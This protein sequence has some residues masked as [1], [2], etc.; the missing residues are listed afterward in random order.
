MWSLDRLPV[1]EAGKLALTNFMKGQGVTAE[2]G[3]VMTLVDEDGN[4]VLLVQQGSESSDAM[5][6]VVDSSNGQDTTDLHIGE[7]I[8][9]YHLLSACSYSP[10]VRMQSFWTENS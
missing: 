4:Q 7:P 5:E 1:A 10:S 9:S 2:G 6:Q 3:T 8:S